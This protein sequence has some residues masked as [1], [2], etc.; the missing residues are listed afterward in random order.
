[1]TLVGLEF[2]SESSRNFRAGFPL[3]MLLPD[4]DCSQRWARLHGSAFVS[5]AELWFSSESLG[6]GAEFAASWT[7]EG[8]KAEVT[9][10]WASAPQSEFACAYLKIRLWP[11]W[12]CKLV[13]L[14][15]SWVFIVVVAA[16][17]LLFKD[18]VALE[19]VHNGKCYVKHLIVLSV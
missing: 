18:D 11:I 19:L 1:M 7:E 8:Q 10:Q 16:H 5:K 15:I 6:F 2:S 12:L 17:L 3:V 13:C 14:F 9:K 4:G